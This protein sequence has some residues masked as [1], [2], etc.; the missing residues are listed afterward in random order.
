MRNK[1][2][3]FGLAMLLLSAVLFTVPL[4]AQVTV[5][6]QTP[7]HSTLEVVA[8]PD[9]AGIADGVMVPRLTL[10]QLNNRSGLYGVAQKVIR[11]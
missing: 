1:N 3:Q 10:T 8:L 5:G 2:K 11:L 6:A 7:P 4:K 9:N